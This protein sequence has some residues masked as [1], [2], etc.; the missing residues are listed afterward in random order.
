VQI[1]GQRRG[2]IESPNY[3][4]AYPASSQCSWTVQAWAG[5]TVSYTFTAFNLEW[6]SNC[7]H[8]HV[9]VRAGTLM[10]KAQSTADGRY[11]MHS[12]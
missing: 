1:S 12:I 8:D 6:S 5:N 10:Q 9:K 2:V 4:N 7:M 11:N 3:P